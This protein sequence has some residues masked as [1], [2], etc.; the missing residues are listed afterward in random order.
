MRIDLRADADARE[1][2]E[3]V[4]RRKLRASAAEHAVHP[5]LRVLLGEPLGRARH[6]VGRA[7][8]RPAGCRFVVDQDRLDGGGAHIDADQ[9]GLGHAVLPNA[10]SAAAALPYS[11]RR[12]KENNRLRGQRNGRGRWRPCATRRTSSN[13]HHSSKTIRGVAF[14]AAA[15]VAGS[16]GAALAQSKVAVITPYMA[17]PGTQ[18]Y[19]EAFQAVAKEKGWDVNVI[20]TA[21][22]VAAV[23]SR[24]EDVVNQGVNAIVIN[25]DPTQ[26]TAGL[27][28]AKDTNIPVVG[29]DAGSDPLLATNV[30]SDGYR[31]GR[32]P[33]PTY[34]VDRIKRRRAMS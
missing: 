24:I 8:T 2:A 25:V 33:L 17:Q 21:G 26:V 1:T 14:A 6:G 34:V 28:T 11:A 30:T 19:V 9:G 29:M 31:H 4:A 3:I 20:D 22:D 5:V 7:K 18:V 12:H 27:Q 16:A 23:I 13:A 32:E 10:R 15:I